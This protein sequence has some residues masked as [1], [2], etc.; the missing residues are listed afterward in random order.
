MEGED[1]AK[2]CHLSIFGKARKERQNLLPWRKGTAI[3]GLSEEDLTPPEGI[4]PD[5]QY[6]M[7]S[8][9]PHFFPLQTLH[10]MN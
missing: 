6:C 8:P 2:T 9:A 1:S 10:V 7:G 5:F 4:F 3:A